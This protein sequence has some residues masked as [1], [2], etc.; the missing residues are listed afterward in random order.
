LFLKKNNFLI[1]ISI[2]GTEEIHDCYR[3]DRG[4]KP[5]FH[6][7]IQGLK[8]LQ[9]YEIEYNV[10]VC[11]TK[12]SSKKPLEIYRFFK[13]MGVRFIQFIPIVER[14]ADSQTIDL[15]LRHATPSSLCDTLQPHK[16]SPWSVDSEE[17]GEF[18]IR[19]F[20]EWIR[21]D[22]GEVHV[23][24]F[25]W[26]LSS[27][28]GLPASVC[29][30]SER[31]GNALVMEHNGDV[32]SCDHY[33][34][35]THRLGNIVSDS[36]ESIVNLES[37]IEFGE[38]KKNGLPLDCLECEFLFACHGECPKHRF[39][40]DSNGEL[41]LNYL[42]RGYKRYFAHI[43]PYMKVLSKFIQEGIPCYKIMDL[44]AQGSKK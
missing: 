42:C 24:N 34:Y 19:V 11:V 3:L 39:L 30:F 10:L 35:P 40:E 4:G 31:C 29:I 41:G 1:G 7:V 25:E 9:K 18:L 37:Q 22:V 21:K 20:D 26:A 27:W 44:L 8:L 15:G 6:K 38:N 43:N 5:T 28:V 2:D 36:L 33:V 13:E 32:F 23:M 14:R 17:Y 16:L 12:E